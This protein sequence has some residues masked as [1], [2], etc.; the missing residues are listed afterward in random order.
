MEKIRGLKRWSAR[1]M[2]DELLQCND[3]D[4]RPVWLKWWLAEVSPKGLR[5]EERGEMGVGDVLPPLA[6]APAE[7]QK[8]AKNR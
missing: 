8:L 1:R 6:G 3:Q 5:V 2:M 4:C 7:H